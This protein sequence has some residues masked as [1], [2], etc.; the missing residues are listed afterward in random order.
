MANHSRRRFL[1]LAGL[2]VVLPAL[3]RAAGAQTYPARPVR[4]MVGFPAGG[5]NDVLA[6]LHLPGARLQR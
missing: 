6:R 2:A 1:H 5:P 3:S 4:L